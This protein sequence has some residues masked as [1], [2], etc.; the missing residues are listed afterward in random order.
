MYKG[1]S[2]G[3]NGPFG[4]AFDGSHIWVTNQGGNSV[5]EINASDGDLR[6]D[7]LRRPP[8]AST[9]RSG[10]AF[11]GSDI[12]VTNQGGNSVTEINASN[13]SFVRTLSG[14]SYGFSEP[15]GVAF[16]GSHIWVVN[17]AGDSVTEI[18]AS[19]GSFVQEALGRLLRLQLP[20]GGGLRRHPHVDH[21]RGG[22]SVTEINA[23]D[24]SWVQTL[25]G[26]SYGFTVPIGI[27]FDGTHLWVTNYNG[28]NSVTEINAS[29][30]SWVQTLS[31]GSY[32]FNF[33]I[34]D[35]LRRHP[36]VG[37]E[38]QRRQLGYR[39]QRQRRELGAD[40][41]GRLVR[42]QRPGW[43]WPSTAATSGSPTTGGNSVTA[44]PAG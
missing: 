42:L 23:S 21:E 32:G 20:G 33:P 13:G 24:G 6:A 25:S 38:F 43:S 2:Y 41:L 15:R 5:T 19:D 14:G 27:A 4:V 16:D 7:A 40:A 1:G 34:R 30:G 22:N 26:G 36:P 44:L 37:H 35:R 9:C 28:G 8:T 11:D 3:F 39:D 18:N 10:V 31:G 29:D 12:W 17:T